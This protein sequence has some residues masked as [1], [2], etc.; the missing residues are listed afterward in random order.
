M[1]VA[2]VRHVRAP[3]PRTRRAA[4]VPHREVIVAEAVLEPPVI[5]HHGRLVALALVTHSSIATLEV[6][7]LPGHEFRL[8]ARADEQIRRADV[9][10]L[11]GA[12]EDGMHVPLAR[13]RLIHA[14]RRLVEH[15]LLM[16]SPG[17]S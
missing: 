14:E 4:V 3:L 8:P 10:S 12:A 7:R 16:P 13:D 1:L 2:P 15:V 11:V 6:L 5:H 17:K 9:G